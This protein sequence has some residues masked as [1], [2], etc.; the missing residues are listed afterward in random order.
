MLTARLP[1]VSRTASAKAT[2]GARRASVLARAE[3]ERKDLVFGGMGADKSTLTYLTG[4]L[5]VPRG[6][7]Y[8]HA[9]VSL[10]PRSRFCAGPETAASTRWACWTP[11][12][13]AGSSPPSGWRTR[14]RVLSLGADTGN[15]A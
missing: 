4:E 5:C 14:R 11:V 8:T 3:P 13:R 2:S 7:S 12:R 10:T 15:P 9:P 6:G 1:S